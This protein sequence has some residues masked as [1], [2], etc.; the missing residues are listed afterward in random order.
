MA[1]NSV[2][3]SWEEFLTPE[4]LRNKLISASIYLAAFQMLKD[5]IVGHL[6]SFYTF[7][8]DKDGDLIDP[9]YEREVLSRNRSVLYASLSWLAESGAIDEKDLGTF[10][11][12]KDCRNQIAH[13]MPQ[14]AL[15][16]SKF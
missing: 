1:K 15:A 3:E 7:G 11:K 14:L 10:E 8:F 4:V 13:N 2:D 6:K 16:G 9:K 12:L 5:S